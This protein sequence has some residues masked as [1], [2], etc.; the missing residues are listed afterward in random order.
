MSL[1]LQNLQLIKNRVIG[2]VQNYLF[3]DGKLQEVGANIPSNVKQTLDCTGWYASE[4]WIDL[5]CGLGEPG[6]EYR[7]T[8]ESLGEVLRASGFCKAV[9]MP[10]TEPPIETVEQAAE[11][12]KEILAA[13]PGYR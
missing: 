11:Y 13:V 3:Q 7:E 2:P 6:Q 8:V 4:G 12:K 9:I 1:F 5:R 10:N